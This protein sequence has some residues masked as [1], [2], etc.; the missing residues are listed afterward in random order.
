METLLLLLLLV[1]VRAHGNKASCDQ[2]V[3]IKQWP[4]HTTTPR[5]RPHSDDDYTLCSVWGDTAKRFSDCPTCHALIIKHSTRRSAGRCGLV[6]HTPNTSLRPINVAED[7]ALSE[8]F[9]R[10]RNDEFQFFKRE[11]ARG[12][13]HADDKREVCR[14]CGVRVSGDDGRPLGGKR[15]RTKHTRAPVPHTRRA[16]G[17]GSSRRAHE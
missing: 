6:S 8:A 16:S 13:P 10:T 12:R 14:V 15:V 17:R 1:V 3:L 7:H 5:E 11:R 2:R 9:A 4:I